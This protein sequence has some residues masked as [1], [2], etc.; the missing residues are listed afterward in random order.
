MGKYVDSI[1]FQ[2]FDP[3]FIIL[4]ENCLLKNVDVYTFWGGGGGGGAEKVYVLYIH[5]SVDNN[6]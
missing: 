4:F 3:F 6:G 1:N 5:L 2:H